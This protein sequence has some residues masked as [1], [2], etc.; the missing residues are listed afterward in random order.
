[1]NPHAGGNRLPGYRALPRREDETALKF[2]ASTA[3]DPSPRIRLE[4]GLPEMTMR[5][6]DLVSP[7]GMGQRGLIVAPPGSGKTTFLKHI[8]RSVAKSH[9]DMKIYALLIDERPEEVTD[10]RRSVP[11]EVRWSSSDESYENHIATADTLMKQVYGEVLGGADVMVLV[12]SLTRLA[13]VHNAERASSGRTLSGGVDARALEVPR[14][15]FGSARKIEHGGSLTILATI[16]VDTGSRMD[17]YI[18]EEFKGT[19]NMEIYLSREIS[20]QRIFPAVDIPKS[21][22]RKEELLLAPDELEPVR[23]VRGALAGLK[24]LESIRAL[25]TQLGKYSTNKDFLSAV[26]KELKT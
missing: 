16:L 7:I 12:D 25:I 11:A 1:M 15:I 13:R 3:V 4:D 26:S 17:Q 8:C 2:R 23:R 20:N 9:P 10:F 6:M 18:F 22:T 24:P 5:V 14:R 21:G 19:G